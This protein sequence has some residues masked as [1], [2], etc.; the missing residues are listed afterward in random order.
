MRSLTL[1]PSGELLVAFEGEFALGRIFSVAVVVAVDPASGEELWRFVEGDETTNRS[2]GGL[3]VWENLVLYS[4][5]TGQ[6]A[7]AFDINTREVVWRAPFLPNSFSGLVPPLVK[8][9]VAYFSDTQGGLFAVDARTGT[10]IWL[11][12]GKTGYF[13]HAVCGDIVFG[14][15]P[16]GEFHR[17]ADGS[18]LGY[19]NSPSS[20]DVVGQVAVADDVL[21]PSADSGVYAY[22]CRL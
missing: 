9:G 2:T 17:R 6:E 11:D 22:D 10:R 16:S 18:F 1:A 19:A 14:I 15:T 3:T 5:G 7:V 8:D 21:Y 4:D 12:D 20:D 13:G